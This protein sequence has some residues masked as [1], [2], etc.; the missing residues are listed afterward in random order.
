MKYMT[1]VFSD[2]NQ[3][4]PPPALMQAI[5]QL[6]IEAAKAGV[7]VQQGGLQRS[8]SGFRIRASKGKLTVTDGPFTESKEVIGGFAVYATDTHEQIVEW[9]RRFMEIHTTHWPEWTGYAEVRPIFEA[10]GM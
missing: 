2:E 10:P 7:L 3:G 6:G 1:M 8:A 4:P 9:T 5:M